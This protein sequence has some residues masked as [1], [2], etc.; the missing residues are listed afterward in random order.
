MDHKVLI[1]H[2]LIHGFTIAH[3]ATAAALSQ[4]MVGDEYKANF[5]TA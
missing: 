1:S 4:T 5:E 2:V 3:A